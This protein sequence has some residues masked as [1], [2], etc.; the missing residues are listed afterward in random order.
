M[1]HQ[2]LLES[3]FLRGTLPKSNSVVVVR[4]QSLSQNLGIPLIKTNAD[5]YTDIEP[6]PLHHCHLET[7]YSRFLGDLHSIL[8]LD[9]GATVVARFTASLLQIQHRR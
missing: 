4:G 8:A 2:R 5:E 9:L 1:A 3:S 7:T 6:G